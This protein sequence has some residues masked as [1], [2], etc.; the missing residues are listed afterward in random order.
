[1]NKFSYSVQLW[2]ERGREGTIERDW[3]KKN[4]NIASFRSSSLGYGTENIFTK[5]SMGKVKKIFCS[6]IRR[7]STRTERRKRKKCFPRSSTI[8]KWS[9]TFQKCFLRLVNKYFNLYCAMHILKDFKGAS[10]EQNEKTKEKMWLQKII[11]NVRLRSSFIS[12]HFRE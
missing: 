7:G 4:L 10:C 3:R 9:L 6:F 5:H 2:W 8:N 12:F 11:I 1:M